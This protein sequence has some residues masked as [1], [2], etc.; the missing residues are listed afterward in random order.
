MIFFIIIKI[1]DICI[2]IAVIKGDIIA[3]RKVTDPQKWLLPLKNLFNQ[4]GKNPENWE[5]AWG[6][7]F[8]LEIQNPA[9]ALQKVIEIKA[10]IKKTK[11][12]GKKK[13]SDIDVRLA[14]GI[15]RKTFTGDRISESN[16]PAFIYA[17]EK[18]DKLKK[19]NLTLGIQSPWSDFDHEINLYLKL[20]GIFMDKWSI[21]SAELVGI[22]LKQPDVL[23]EELGKKLGIKQNS[24][25][26]RWKRACLND[27]LEIEKTYRTKLTK[28]LS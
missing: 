28:M 6:D 2:M 9:E 14:L 13:M 24:V 22:V 12:N 7:A 3:S 21:S 11:T 8:Q 26:G 17:A 19:E 5:L 1:N 23:Q 10:L 18:F 20:G 27:V 25:S 16:G 4:W 15:G